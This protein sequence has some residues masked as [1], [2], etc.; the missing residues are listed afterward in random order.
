MKYFV[1]GI[2]VI[3]FIYM[4]VWSLKLY[5]HTKRQKKVKRIQELRAKGNEP[6]KVDPDDP[7]DYW[8][9]I[10][11]VENCAE[12]E[13]ERYYHYFESTET[14]MHELLLEMYDC[15][16]VRTDELNQI[17]YGK[18]RFKD[19]DLSFLEELEREMMADE[20]S[21]QEEATI[22]DEKTKGNMDESSDAKPVEQPGVADTVP[23]DDIIQVEGATGDFFSKKQ[24]DVI[25][26]AKEL[27]KDDPG[28][29]DIHGTLSA[30]VE[31]V[32][33]AVEAEKKVEEEKNEPI[34]KKEEKSVEEARKARELTSNSQIRNQVYEKWIGYVDELFGL[35]HIHSSEETKQKLRKALTEYGYNDVDVLLESP[36]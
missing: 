20:T 31:N 17:A 30:G 2:L 18:N 16:V 13:R 10:R 25:T 34:I 5:S 28:I 1:I 35:V 15:G 27:K 8:Y 33:A 14:A 7:R 9:N 4:I 11:E 12:D 6:K 24:S 36:E 29:M 23:L 19:M 3:F 26:A 22:E 21:S 32:I